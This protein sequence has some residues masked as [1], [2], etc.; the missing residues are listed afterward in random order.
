[1][2]IAAL[3]AADKETALFKAA[4]A[5]SFANHQTNGQVT[6]GAD[7]YVSGDKV[8][9][10]FG[11]LDPYQYGVLPVLVVIQNDSGK[12]IRLDELKA[13]YVGPNNDRVEATPAKEVRYLEGPN[14][15]RMIPGPGGQVK[16][17]KGKNPLAAWE[18]E[19]R[20]MAA[21]MLPAG[22]TA[23]GF[24]Y[25]QTG[26]QRGATLYLSGLSEAAT[27]KELLYFELT[28]Q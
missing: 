4:S 7:A 6:I 3:L 20:A 26:L 17:L 25:F 1:M 11:K 15:P 18:I 12:T 22:Q 14:R 21:Q 9:T 13:V 27:G 5:G 19:G 2:S 16:V 8:K 24:F 23:S 10:A 28:L